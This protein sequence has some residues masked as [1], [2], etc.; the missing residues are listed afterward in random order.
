MCDPAALQIGTTF[1]FFDESISRP[2]YKRC[3]VVGMSGDGSQLAAVYINSEIAPADI[4]SPELE[5]LHLPISFTPDRNYIVKD[6]FVDC[7]DLLHLFPDSLCRNIRDKNGHIYGT[8]LPED[9]LA[10]NELLV[11]G[12]SIPA[13]YLKLYQI[14]NK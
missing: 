12:G 8:A 6:S 1:I 10:I 2:H 11:S 14:T 7:S 4:G 3:I 13:F 5:A 9:M